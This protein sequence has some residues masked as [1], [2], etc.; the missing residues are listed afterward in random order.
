MRTLLRRAADALIATEREILGWTLPPLRVALVESPLVADPPDR[1]CHR[2]GQTVGHGELTD[3]GCA[4]CRGRPSA[5]AATVR[6]AEYAGDLASSVLRIKRAGWF[7]LGEEI[8]RRLGDQVERSLSPERRPR[9]LV[10]VPMPW[11][12]RWQRGID[13]ARVLADAAALRLGVPVAQPLRHRNGPSQVSRTRTERQRASD[14]IR[15]APPKARWARR[16]AEA[17]V[18]GIVDDVRTTG[19]TLEQVARALRSAGATDVVA[20]VAAVVPSPRRRQVEREPAEPAPGSR[21]LWTTS[22]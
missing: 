6:L 10:P 18:V 14:R 2:C 15:L 22:E 3:R 4:T 12:R 1:W 17:G 19:A 7:E 5:I 20:I 21:G 11:L 16:L 8:G 13:H 9:L